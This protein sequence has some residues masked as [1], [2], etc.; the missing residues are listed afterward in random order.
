[1]AYLGEYKKNGL[2]VP[3][4][5]PYNPYTRTFDGQNTNEFSMNLNVIVNEVLCTFMFVS[6]VLVV[7]GKHTAGD[8][9]GI[10]GLIACCLTLMSNLASTSRLGA[11]YN[12][13]VGISLTLN[14]IW[15]L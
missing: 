7:K 4:M 9:K 15:L 12:P 2:V 13:A 10:R 11:S 5:A 14:S 6:V 3:I 1:M 8:A